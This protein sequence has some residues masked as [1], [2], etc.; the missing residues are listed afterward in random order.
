MYTYRGQK[1]SE[2]YRDPTAE[3]AISLMARDEKRKKGK[4]H[5]KRAGE[6]KEHGQVGNREGL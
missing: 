4:E 5:E 6:S 3:I 2:G 1:N